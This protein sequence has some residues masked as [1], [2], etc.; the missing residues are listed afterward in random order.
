MPISIVQYVTH[1]CSHRSLLPRVGL[2]SASLVGEVHAEPLRGGGDV[3]KLSSSVGRSLARGEP[4]FV[5]ADGVA[6]ESLHRLC[7]FVDELVG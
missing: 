6:L 5:Q 3:E 7:G 2:F 4:L 1:S